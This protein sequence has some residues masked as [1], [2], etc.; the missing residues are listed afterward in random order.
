MHQPT[1]GRHSRPRAHTAIARLHFRFPFAQRPAV[2]P[3]APGLGEPDA[4]PSMELPSGHMPQRPFDT[5]LLKVTTTRGA[6]IGHWTAPVPV[7]ALAVRDRVRVKD[8]VKDYGGQRGRVALFAEDCGLPVGVEFCNGIGSHTAY[9]ARD[10]VERDTAP[11]D[12]I[13]TERV[14]DE[15][16]RGWERD[17]LAAEET[18]DRA[19]ESADRLVAELQAEAA[20]EAPEWEDGDEVAADIFGELYD[21]AEGVVARVAPHRRDGRTVGV[22]TPASIHARAEGLASGIVWFKP[23][24]LRSKARPVEATLVIDDLPLMGGAR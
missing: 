20:D 17:L 12:T 16:L 24:E 15:P 11:A 19:I 8:E 5:V 7:P 4:A 18:L 6:S 10:E 2:A 9:F 1:R 23:S 13:P 21:G 22:D 14:H 3:A